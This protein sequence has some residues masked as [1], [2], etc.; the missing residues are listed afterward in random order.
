VD[1]IADGVGWLANPV[2]WQGRDGIPTR[3]IEHVQLSG[4]SLLLAIVIALPVGLFIGHT[5]RGANL[6]INLANLG[7]A[8]PTLA[9]MAI[10]GSLTV[11]IDP[12]LGFKLYSTLI[13][14]IVLAV[15]P[16]LVNSYAGVSGVDRELVEAARGMGMRERQILARM[17]IPIA[18]PVIVGGIRSGA[19]QIVATATLGA[20]FGGG[21]LGRY[22]ID[23]ISQG[24][25]APGKIFGG[26]VLVAA[27][28]LATE[29]VFALAQRALVSPGLVAPAP[30]GS[31]RLQPG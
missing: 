28:A 5:G 15:P 16:I 10:A 3:L 11:L 17:E 27:L 9:V 29:A 4:V 12:Q 20:I 14:M 7:R 8:L 2:N 26:V 23:G 31:S 13:G 24:A 25:A 30:G 22:L 19:V 6:A 18:L 21:G 1:L